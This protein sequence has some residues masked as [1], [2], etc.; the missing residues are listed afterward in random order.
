MV[1]ERNCLLMPQ[2]SHKPVPVPGSPT[3][4]QGLLM[5]TE[6]ILQCV[7]SNLDFCKPLSLHA[8]TCK[9]VSGPLTY[10]FPIVTSVCI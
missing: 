1:F 2:R 9:E 6:G 8:Y 3:T 7:L 5:I 10:G 4:P